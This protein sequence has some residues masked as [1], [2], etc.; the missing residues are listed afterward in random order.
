MANFRT[1]PQAQRM[2]TGP[3]GRSIASYATY[4]EAQTAVDF[5]SDE[6]FPVQHVSI[7]GTDLRMVERVLGRLTYGRVALAGLGSGAWIG[8]LIGLI[9]LLFSPPETGL[10]T[11][12]PAV[13][14]G[15]GF[16]ILFS[17]FSYALTRGR[18][19]FTSVSQIV[20]S[21]YAV[22]CADEHAAAAR[23]VLGRNSQVA[24]GIEQDPWAAGRAAPQAGPPH[25][26]QQ[27]AP[28]DERQQ[29][30]WG[31]DQPSPQ[32]GSAASEAPA[33]PT[34]SGPTYSEMVARQREA[35]RQKA[36]Q[37][38]AERREAEERARRGEGGTGEGGTEQDG[39]R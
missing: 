36:E 18:R 6:E 30:G 15:A 38:E 22:F 8:L 21:R 11:L 1:S 29:R 31:G 37:R 20:A 5:L 10:V 4:A 33:A 16:G 27:A 23:D 9:L 26:A 19:D 32:P 35:E 24:A 12:L 34:A 28:W 2:P 3:T 13:V 17:L 25:G 7:V 39:A 14:I